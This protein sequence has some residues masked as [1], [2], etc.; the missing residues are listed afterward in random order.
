MIRKWIENYLHAR[1]IRRLTKDLFKEKT[2]YIELR[3]IS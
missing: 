2:N 3:K 1:R